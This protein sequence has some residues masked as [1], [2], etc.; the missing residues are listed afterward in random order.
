MSANMEKHRS[1]IPVLLDRQSD[2]PNRVE[3]KTSTRYHIVMVRQRLVGSEDKG[4]TNSPMFRT[5][6]ARFHILVT[7]GTEV[8]SDNL[9]VGILSAIVLGHFEHTKVQVRHWTEGATSYQ[10]DRSLGR[11]SHDSIETVVRK[12]VIGRVCEPGL[13]FWAGH[14]GGVTETTDMGLDWSCVVYCR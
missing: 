3:I 10:D 11:V 13:G 8:A 2:S 4:V 12:R 9:E 1:A 7:D 5:Q 6:Q 14:D